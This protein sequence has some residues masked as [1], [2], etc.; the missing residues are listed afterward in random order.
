MEE[1]VKA[2]RSYKAL[3]ALLLTHRHPSSSGVATKGKRGCSWHGTGK[4]R[5]MES[6]TQ[7]ASGRQNQVWKGLGR[8]QPVMVHAKVAP[9]SSEKSKGDG[10]VGSEKRA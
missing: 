6:S 10:T 3:V 2:S 7:S 5:S 9:T 4:G 1:K 8:R